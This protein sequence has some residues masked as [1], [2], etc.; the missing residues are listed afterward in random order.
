[1]PNHV[2]SAL[3]FEGI[4]ILPS[5]RHTSWN[6]RK[7]SAGKFAKASPDPKIV[8][9]VIVDFQ[10]IRQNQFHRL[11]NAVR[12]SMTEDPDTLHRCNLTTII[13]AGAVEMSPSTERA[14]LSFDLVPSNRAV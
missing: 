3:Q 2:G 13:T 8:T 4:V 14:F 10:T 11:L 6:T 5:A 7:A 12:Y 1:M 9:I